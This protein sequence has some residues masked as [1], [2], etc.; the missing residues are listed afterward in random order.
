MKANYLHKPFI[1][2]FFLLFAGT[3]KTNAQDN[4]KPATVLAVRY[5]LF[6]NKIPYVDVTTKIKVGKKFEAVPGIPVKIYFNEAGEKNLLGKVTTGIDGEGKVGLP[7]SFKPTWDSLNEFKF[8]A[9][10]D[11]LAGTESMNAD[12][13]VKK[14]ILVLDTANL[15]GT[16]TVSAQL[17]EKKGNEWVAVKD[18]EMKLGIKRLYANLSVGDAATYTSDSS[19][20]ASTEF[21]R[22]SMPG[23]DKGNLV[24]MARVD[25]NETYGNLF[26]EKT[27]PW[28][29]PVQ[30]NTNFWHRTL[31]STGDRAPVW[32][33]FIALSIIIG[34]WGTIIYLVR[35]MLTVKRLGMEF[36]R[37]LAKS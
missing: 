2:L 34:V 28:G 1:I 7:A 30:P 15:D 3:S 6:N 25:D 16:R 12:V 17:K 10:S 13:T 8:I 33:L 36:D 23:D 9:V 11:S 19:G 37:R 14:S 32:L 20:V 18:I 24:L 31:W 29:L 21:K 4:E 35:R 26:V 22:D 27:V 5:F